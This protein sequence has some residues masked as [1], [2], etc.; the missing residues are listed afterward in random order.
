MGVP[1]RVG[2][3]VLPLAVSAVSEEDEPFPEPP[4]LPVQ[5]QKL[6]K[7]NIKYYSICKE[8]SVHLIADQHIYSDL[9]SSK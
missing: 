3:A 5:Y 4:S 7:R 9:H 6:I 8:I 2:A 1:A